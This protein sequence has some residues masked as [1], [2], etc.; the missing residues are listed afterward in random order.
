MYLINYS[1]RA[2]GGIVDPTCDS[3]ND[4]PRSEPYLN[5]NQ[6]SWSGFTSYIFW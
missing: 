2:G 6:S 4:W 1:D 5:F 3:S